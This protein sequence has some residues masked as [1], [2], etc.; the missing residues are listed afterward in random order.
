M[1]SYPGSGTVI[2]VYVVGS[3]G[4]CSYKLHG[5]SIKKSRTASCP[6]SDHEC[7]GILHI[8]VRDRTSILVKDLRIRFEHSFEKRYAFVYYN[9]LNH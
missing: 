4:R 7:I 2:K 3:Y 1:D 5:R 8:I 9:L 6:R